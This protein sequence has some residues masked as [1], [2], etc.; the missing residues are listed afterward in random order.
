MI[1]RA[2]SSR[3]DAPGYAENRYTSARDMAQDIVRSYGKPLA[4]FDSEKSSTVP[5]TEECL[6][7]T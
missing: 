6:R 2:I 7:R 5:G 3:K 4:S 1:A